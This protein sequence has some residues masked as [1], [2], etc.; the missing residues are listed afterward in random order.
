MNWLFLDLPFTCLCVQTLINTNYAFFFLPK[1]IW[2]ECER[3]ETLADQEGKI[4]WELRVRE[5]ALE[6]V[7]YE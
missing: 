3:A 4:K 5:G 1:F 6:S 2:H 7:N